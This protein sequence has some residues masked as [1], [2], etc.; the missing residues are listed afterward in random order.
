MYTSHGH[1]IAGTRVE[2][3]G[4]RNVIT[5]G[6]PQYCIVCSREVSQASKNFEMFDDLPANEKPDNPLINRPPHYISHPSGVECIEVTRHMNF[7]L[8][9][10]VKYIWRCELKDPA[11]EIQDLKKAIWYLN[12]EIVRLTES[13]EKC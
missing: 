1:H 7:N 10:A 2:N 6:G 3:L 8:G 13:E 4:I 11:L 12:D 5:C 9:N